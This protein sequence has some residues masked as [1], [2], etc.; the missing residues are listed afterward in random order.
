VALN[1]GFEAVSKTIFSDDRQSADFER[2]YPQTWFC[3]LGPVQMDRYESRLI[4]L[5]SY[6]MGGAP[7]DFLSSLAAGHPHFLDWF[8][9]PLVGNAEAQS[10]I[11]RLLHERPYATEATSAADVDSVQDATNIIGHRQHTPGDSRSAISETRWADALCH[12]DIMISNEAP[13][14]IAYDS[15]VAA[16]AVDLYGTDFNALGYD[17]DSWVYQQ[18]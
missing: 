14:A 5:Q 10:I 18:R 4:D 11:A 2:L 17:R 13:S 16:L 8:G 3:L 1:S 6:F 12:L 9:K 7:S 15:D